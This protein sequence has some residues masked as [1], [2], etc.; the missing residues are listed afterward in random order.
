EQAISP[1]R[2]RMIDDMTIR[3]IGQKTKEDYIL[4]LSVSEAQVRLAAANRWI[5]RTPTRFPSSWPVT[6]ALPALRGQPLPTAVDPTLPQGPDGIAEEMRGKLTLRT[7]TKSG[8]ETDEFYALEH[9]AAK[10]FCGI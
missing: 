4:A 6:G 2:Q 3:G 1:L 7:T 10:K 9:R 8:A 5:A